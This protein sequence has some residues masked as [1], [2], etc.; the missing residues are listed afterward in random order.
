MIFQ[1]KGVHSVTLSLYILIL[2]FLLSKFFKM[3]VETMVKIAIKPY[4]IT[5]LGQVKAHTVDI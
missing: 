4:T 2:K 1:P 5:Q 3:D